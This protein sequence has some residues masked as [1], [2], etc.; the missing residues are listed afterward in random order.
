[1]RLI[2]VDDVM[3]KY[4]VFAPRIRIAVAR[5]ALAALRILAGLE[6]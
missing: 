2:A 4:A 6:A 3:E 1:M 5:Q